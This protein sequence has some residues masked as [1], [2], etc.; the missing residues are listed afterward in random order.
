MVSVSEP[1]NLSPNEHFERL[2]LSAFVAA[3]WKAESEPL[4]GRR[5]P[6]MLA[7]KG[8]HRYVVELKAASEGRRDRLV[9]LLSQAILQA[10]LHASHAAGASPLAVIGAPKIPAAVAN[11]LRE[12][13]KEHAPE[14]A[15][16]L[17]DHHGLRSFVGPGLEA[18]NAEPNAPRSSELPPVE[19]SI[20]LFSDLN[21]WMLKG[22]LAPNIERAELMPAAFPRDGYRNASELARAAHVSVMSA[23]RFLRQLDREGFLHES[24]ER[25]RLVRVD[26]LL[27]RWLAANQ[28]P[29]RELSARWILAGAERPLPRAIERLGKRACVG[30]FSAA[31]AMGLGHVQGVPLHVYVNEF[32]SDILKKAGLMKAEAGD[33]VDVVLRLPS[34]RASV[35][36]AIVNVDGLPV[37]DVLQVWLDV[38]AH[39]ARGKE[40]ADVIY[41]RVIKPMIG[42]ANDFAR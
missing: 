19:Q 42:R 26:A 8:Q 11:S 16:G 35:F 1:S 22:L 38:S 15:V 13:A 30:L 3:G 10:K 23:F 31:R 32:R 17:L 29:A 37:S 2:L 39:P 25:V 12:F 41:R 40:Q 5:R 6:D 21:Q 7:K 28:K 20:D 14:V 33:R 36:R 24:R 9:A 4:V 34:A 27:Q 18:L